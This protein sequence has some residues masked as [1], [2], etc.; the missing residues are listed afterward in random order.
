M[1]L[2]EVLHSYFKQLFTLTII[3]EK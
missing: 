1:V 3:S 2:E